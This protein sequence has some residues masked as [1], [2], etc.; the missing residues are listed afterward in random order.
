[1][2]AARLHEEGLVKRP[3]FHVDFNELIERDLVLLSK[4]DTKLT[5]TGESI[6]LCEGLAI[7]VYD[8]DVDD[9][10]EPDNLIAS[11]IVERNSTIGW[12][13]DVKWNCRIDSRGIRHE[14][15]LKQK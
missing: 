8:D 1:M 2:K 13:K 3:R 15:D 11:G 12:A 6:F 9:R 7:E 10:G 14:S 4:D 5:S